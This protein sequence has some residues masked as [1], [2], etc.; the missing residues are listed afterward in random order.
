[1]RLCKKMISILLV[2][3]LMISMLPVQALAADA[4][5]PN[6]LL[7]EGPD[8]YDH[9][10]HNVVTAYSSSNEITYPLDNG[11]ELRF[12]ASTGTITRCIQ[13]KQTS[14]EIPSEINGTAVTA[15]GNR[16]FLGCGNVKS[17][18]IPE[19]V[20]S[21][22]TYAFE[23]CKKLI[24]V[25]IP[26]AVTEI[27]EG[28]F[29]GCEK[30]TNVTIPENVTHIGSSAFFLSGLKSVSLPSGIT[31]IEDY[32]F[33]WCDI[34]S[35]TIP[36][37][38]TSIKNCAFKSCNQLISVDI[39]DNVTE[40]GE[41]AFM[42]CEV[43]QSID[44]PAKVE[45]IGKGAFSNCGTLTTITVGEVN[46]F[47]CS[48][49]NVLFD[50]KCEKLIQ[51]P[52]GYKGSYEIPK[53][54]TE[55]EE[56]AFQ[57]CNS[58][59]SVVVPDGVKSIKNVFSSCRQLES[60]TLPNSITTLDFGAFD[61][62]SSLRDITIPESVT[63]IGER[64]FIYCY[65]LTSVQISKSV[66]SIGDAA[67]ASCSSLEEIKVD[68]ENSNFCDVD[69]V[70]FNK[71]K[72]VLLQYPVGKKD[73]SGNQAARYDI[74]NG[75]REIGTY[76]FASDSAL[77]V[78][79]IPDGVESIGRSAFDGCELTEL[80]LP[81]TVK[82]IGSS[83]FW[84][85]RFT[86]LKLT[87]GLESIATY[88]FSGCSSLKSVT[89]PASVTA[90]EE[91]P[92]AYCASLDT[93][94]VAQG[95]QSYCAVD[96]VLL[97]A[98]ADRTRLIQY[99][100][101]KTDTEYTIPESVT[102]I[103]W[104]AFYNCSSLT[105]LTIGEQV[106]V[107]GDSVLDPA[108]GFTIYC[109]AG[110]AAMEYALDKN[111]EY[112]LLTRPSRNLSVSVTDENG[113]PVTEG[114]TVTW[115]NEDNE[116]EGTGDTLTGAVQARTYYCE[117]T[118]ESGLAAK[119]EQPERQT[120]AGISV[121]NGNP[122]NITIPLSK[123]KTIRLNGKV[124]TSEKLAISDVEVS[125]SVKTN[126]GGEVKA[127][128]GSDGSFSLDVP[129]DV[130]SVS[131]R[132]DGYYTG[133]ITLDL[134]KE[135]GGEYNAEPY[136]LIATLSERII[137]NITQKQASQDE[138]QAVETTLSSA[139]SLDFSL[140]NDTTG[141][142]VEGFDV[143]GG[144]LIFAPGTVSGG[145]KI[146]VT[147]SDPNKAYVCAAPVSVTLNESGIG[148]ANITMVQKGS[149]VLG[150]L[151]GPEA[152]MMVFDSSGKAV[153]TE[154]AK[155]GASSG[156]MYAGTYNVVMLAKNDLVRSVPTFGYL[157]EIGLSQGSDYLLQSVTIQDG[158]ITALNDCAV[159]DFDGG[160]I[161]YTAS[162]SVTTSKPG[163]VAAGEL[164]LLRVAY[165]LDPERGAAGNVMK[166]ALPEGIDFIAQ[167]VIID[168]KPT[169][170][171]YN[172]ES[173]EV[174]VQMGG[175]KSAVV[176]LY[177][178]ASE[179]GKHNVS[180][181]LSL[182]NGV[183]QP[184]GS[185]VIKA[186]TAQFNTPA[187]TGKAEGITA[188]GKVLPNSKVEL[189]DNGEKVGETSSNAAGSWSISFDLTKPV[190]SY[191][192]HCLNLVITD[193]KL[194]A[195]ITTEETLLVYS[196]EWSHELDKITMFVDGG[197]ETVFDFKNPSTK[198][199]YY[200]LTS[201][202][203]TL[204]FMVE[205][206][207][208][209]AGAA[210]L[211]GV[212]LALTD[213]IGK[214]T[215]LN[216]VYDEA[217]GAWVGTFKCG[218][219]DDAPVKVSAG[220]SVG[221]NG[222]VNQDPQM[223]E[224]F[225]NSLTTAIKRVENTT[226]SLWADSLLVE[227]LEIDKTAKTSSGTFIFTDPDTDVRET[228]GRFETSAEKADDNV[229]AETLSA[230]G[231]E[232][233]EVNEI[234]TKT[235][236]NNGSSETTI[237]V[238]LK[239][240][241][242]LTVTMIP[243]PASGPVY[244][245]DPMED[246][247]DLASKEVKS[248]ITQL[249]AIS[250]GMV[251]GGLTTLAMMAGT[252]TAP[253]AVPTGAAAGSATT[254]AINE[255][256]AV[257]DISQE[258]K[259]MKRWQQGKTEN[260]KD[261]LLTTSQMLHENC[262]LDGKPLLNA[263]DKK[264]LI[265]R[266]QIKY[267]EINASER[268]V[269]NK[270]DAAGKLGA[271]IAGV[272][273]VM[274]SNTVMIEEFVETMGHVSYQDFIEEYSQREYEKLYKQIT[275][276]KEEIKR[277]YRKCEPEPE[278]G[279]PDPSEPETPEPELAKPVNESELPNDLVEDVGQTTTYIA[280]P[281]GYVYEAVP[282][283][284]LEGVTAT[285]YYRDSE[286]SEPVLW[287]AGDYDQINPQT[288]GTDGGYYW[289]V[290][291]GEWKVVFHKDGYKDTDTS[292]NEAS[293]D[294]GWLPVPPPQ[295]DI[296]VGMVS[297]SAPKITYTEAYTDGVDLVFSQY[298]GIASVQRAVSLARNGANI[299]VSVKAVDAESN[300]ENTAQYATRFLVTTNDGNNSG[301]LKI[302]VTNAAVNYAG[303]PLESAYTSEDMTAQPRPTS[304]DATDNSYIVL[305]TPTA[306]EATLQPGI[307]GKTLMV[308]NLSPRM[309]KADKTEVITGAGGK[310]SVTLEGLLPGVAQ[311]KISEPS[312]GLSRTITVNIALTAVE[313]PKP[314]TASLADGTAVTNGMQLTSGSKITLKTET[315]GA[316]I[317]YTLDDTCPCTGDALTY[318]GPITVTQNTVLRAVAYKDD[319]CGETI[320][321][322]L[323]VKS[324]DVQN[325]GP[326][327]GGGEDGGDQPPVST[328]PSGT[329][330]NAKVKAT[331]NEK[332]SYTAKLDDKTAQSTISDAVKNKSR[333]VEIEVQAPDDA[334]G[335]ALTMPE[336]FAKE[337]F[338]KTDAELSVDTP[339]ATILLPKHAVGEL[340]EKSKN[341]IGFSVENTGKSIKIAILT[342]DKDSGV[343][344]GVKA[345]IPSTAGAASVAIIVNPDGTETMI[346]KSMIRDGVMALE[347]DGG[348][349]I[350]IEDRSKHFDD[351]NDHWAKNYID[352]VT[353]RDLFQ[354][355]SNEEFAPNAQMTRAMLVT[356]L[357]RLEDKPN[358]GSN[359]FSDVPDGI[360][361]ANAM[362]WAA[363]NKI[364]TGKTDTLFAPND[365]V[366]REQLA[367][368]LYR[369][370][371]SLG[372]NTDVKN[373]DMSK[374][375]DAD[376]VSDYASNAVKWAVGAGII[377]GKTDTTIDPK[378]NATRAEVSTM[379]MRLVD[380]MK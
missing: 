35:V 113:N 285:I 232:F 94:T 335:V 85:C 139:E 311:L 208:P 315:Q 162:A 251:V 371:E 23:N 1:M 44:V 131:M 215:Y 15:I 216:T 247:E 43:L 255:A 76:A 367:A 12:D 223:L 244:R 259:A 342:D 17:V 370:T 176:W 265:D 149:F 364:V 312:S 331:K 159:P 214:K 186:E 268:R 351:I 291:Q 62:C 260:L 60:V 275:E 31:S 172:S 254:F 155:A 16:A 22:G 156:T 378:G 189:Y 299:P 284:K 30:L 57:G 206:A 144:N 173:R 116:V 84:G 187:R 13:N 65:A 324:S 288:T 47:Y 307:E 352:F 124:Q 327:G 178:T 26:E 348:A 21:I 183:T 330:T 29:Y 248:S 140:R 78:I 95:S 120:I 334:P 106:K 221:G 41:E 353:G 89:I 163:G 219:F 200:T 325:S 356:V 258:K 152:V 241:E 11:A 105:K 266:C 297:T 233:Q 293:N 93:I 46:N 33:G 261:Y 308:E 82:T 153:K 300:A 347:T 368:I 125:V 79:T 123:R 329:P 180:A 238:D 184:I 67:F 344:K 36:D 90:I 263:Y 264:R 7:R 73:A 199:P 143:Q 96:D 339:L 80:E 376:S 295:V 246:F 109:Y 201:S 380:I 87:E 114:F 217:S 212:Y 317:R 354:G 272:K 133:K 198:Q 340:A 40:I 276:I 280:D 343:L 207:E 132:K 292:I 164:L 253:A 188:R 68:A 202:T 48:E 45:S 157:S 350:R 135:T 310:A 379:L 115:Y 283:N 37:S 224:D 138:A 55:I 9:D 175:R 267:Q 141:A 150:S 6:E 302:S 49:N 86:S 130:L 301:K 25:N 119:Y 98:D 218:S 349:E 204:S 56:F 77:T 129:R 319:I 374:Y 99:P 277:C 271:G 185:T 117:V 59:T 249:M 323:T 273:Q 118:L 281:S 51:C 177:C 377:N 359:K 290:P 101:G 145:D 121:E 279:T 213:N 227:D 195:P 171:N 346:R 102:E 309:V 161:S 228:W 72:T 226:A 38:V 104:G 252:I 42:Y 338:D 3:C 4:D 269:F 134:T 108:Q 294:D 83:A 211:S 235:I 127:H 363:A 322:E 66:T 333:K 92:F 24:S 146:T 10:G 5:R 19:S 328:D 304:I 61:S 112:V 337:L 168:G 366:T 245:S 296:N 147:V 360:W 52:G 181:S 320:R 137:L 332:G 250:I 58:L 234:W 210:P 369:Y 88:A 373:V 318:T 358:G 71:A 111:I 182:S 126:S 191:S 110:T 136:V 243:A 262:Y 365:P 239:N 81:S 321:L 341:T 203:P 282:S 230:D 179:S 53:T 193:S 237:N 336:S 196:R 270:I 345:F 306:L 314:V 362:N 192:H 97:T 222:M 375:Q 18:S 167:S 34:E 142:A 151:T 100:S 316:V 303:T 257:W 69:G 361:Y 70:L 166:V 165:E 107:L 298:M 286:N 27:P 240:K 205:F 39:P 64:A 278:P 63:S 220:Y 103:A 50:K 355:M 190:Y 326:G 75:V 274:D 8:A 305:H 313:T 357:H 197:Q 122:V 256:F 236:K 231:F 174:S 54:V 287:N 160:N 148:S 242:K 74:P 20:T 91:A 169:G 14:I 158:K 2:W 194:E 289:D 372:M 28:S 32:T 128:T 229:T 170:Y 225:E 154:S 209:P